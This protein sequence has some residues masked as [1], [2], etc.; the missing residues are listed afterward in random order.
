M[1]LPTPEQ[2]S[3][4][5]SKERSVAIQPWVAA[6]LSDVWKQMKSRIQTTIEQKGKQDRV[7]ISQVKPASAHNPT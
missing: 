1:S 6:Q 5:V 7:R 4:E 2:I 3:M